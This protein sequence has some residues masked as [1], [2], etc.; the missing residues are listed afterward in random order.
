MESDFYEEGTLRAV[1]K[2][3]PQIANDP[4]F[5]RYP[6]S[7]EDSIERVAGSPKAIKAKTVHITKNIQKMIEP[8]GL[9]IKRI[10]VYDKKNVDMGIGY[11]RDGKVKYI[12]DVE[13][14]NTGGTF[15]DDGKFH[16][17]GLT[18]PQE[19]GKYFDRNH[20][21]YSGKWNHVPFFFCKYDSLEFKWCT[22]VAVSACFDRFS[23][24][25]ELRKAWNENEEFAEIKVDRHFYKIPTSCLFVSKKPY[26]LHRLAVQNITHA[27][28]ALIKLHHRQK[29]LYEY[30]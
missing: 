3:Y 5:V 25:K 16:W 10:N 24:V 23:K 4:L 13:G 1:L 19:K 2:E 30:F 28:A 11:R 17:W 29:S 21:R 20:P 15:E 12:M 18:I 7:F 8:G 14:D 22:V 6:F 27:L 9:F 26:G